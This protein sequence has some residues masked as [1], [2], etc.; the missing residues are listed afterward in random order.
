[1]SCSHP[2]SPVV[3]SRVPYRRGKT[4]LPQQL[5]FGPSPIY[6][7]FILAWHLFFFAFQRG[8]IGMYAFPIHCLGPSKNGCEASLTSVLA[9][10][11]QRSGMNSSALAKNWL[12]RHMV[13][14]WICSLAFLVAQYT[15]CSIVRRQKGTNAF[16]DV[17][18]VYHRA[19]RIPW[20][21]STSG[22]HESQGFSDHRSEVFCVR[23]QGRRDLLGAVEKW[24]DFLHQFSI[25]SR[26]STVSCR[27]RLVIEFRQ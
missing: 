24:Q 14:G 17:T 16:G 25:G 19:G 13:H 5:S 3:G 6:P 26:V 9:G 1:M 22:R 12:L 20:K 8:E 7:T 10:S 23:H 21:P 11:S 2:P 18:P 15:I 27:F 4:C